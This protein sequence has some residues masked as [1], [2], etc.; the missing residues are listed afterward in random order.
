MCLYL[1]NKEAK[2][3]ISDKN[4]HVYKIVLRSSSEN[5][6]VAPIMKTAHEF[7]KELEACDHLV[8]ENNRDYNCRVINRGF[9][10]YIK[11]KKVSTTINAIIPKG[12]EYC[13]G[14]YGEVVSNKIIVF[15]SKEK[16]DEYLK[17]H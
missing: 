4:T 15:S 8:I 2:I 17:T 6:W 13:I 5:M 11:G 3:E 9:H 12:A 10:A 7:D 14:E 16:L 1:F